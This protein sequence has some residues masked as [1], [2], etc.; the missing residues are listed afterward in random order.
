MSEPNGFVSM[1]KENGP[2]CGIS[3]GVPTAC[4]FFKGASNYTHGWCQ[5]PENRVPPSEGWPRGFEPS[6]S[7]TSG[8]CNLREPRS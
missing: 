1:L 6:V 3:S 5:H 7:P 4:R 8:G 2:F